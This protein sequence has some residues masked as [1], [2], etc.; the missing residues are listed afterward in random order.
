MLHLSV[1]GNIAEFVGQAN[2]E[3][4]VRGLEPVLGPCGVSSLPVHHPLS[5]HHPPIRFLS[6]SHVSQR[7][8]DTEKRWHRL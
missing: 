1:H 8:T 2:D 3:V 4:R 5:R 7:G 6:L